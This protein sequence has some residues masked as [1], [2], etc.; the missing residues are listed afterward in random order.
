[1]TA[2]QVPVV[3]VAGLPAD[4]EMVDVREAREWQAGHAPNAVHLPMSELI[5]RI[6]ELPDRDPL[7]VVCAVGS[8]SARV[9]AY[10]CG[11]GYPA[12]NVAGGMRAWQAAG[13]PITA[14]GPAP[15]QIV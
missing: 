1:M 6:G 13:R 7:Y 9:V 2:P 15:P 3:E 14:D 10:L 12:V 5:A 11:Q 8:R 4:A